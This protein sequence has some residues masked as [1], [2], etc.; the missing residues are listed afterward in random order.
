MLQVGPW[1][2]GMQRRCSKALESE[3]RSLVE[4]QVAIMD[5][6][7]RSESPNIQFIILLI[8]T[9]NGIGCSP[10]IP[11]INY[12]YF[13]HLTNMIQIGV[14]FSILAHL[15]SSQIQFREPQYIHPNGD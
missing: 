7:F 8:Q 15:V 14:H 9:E 2:Q 11:S 13:V 3:H 1:R 6:L 12:M 4:E 10:W 5:P